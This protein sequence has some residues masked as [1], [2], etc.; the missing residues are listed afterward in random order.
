MLPVQQINDGE[1]TLKRSREYRIAKGVWNAGGILV[2][3]LIIWPNLFY[4]AVIQIAPEGTNHPYRAAR[5]LGEN[6]SIFFIKLGLK[7]SFP[8]TRDL[9]VSRAIASYLDEYGGNSEMWEIVISLLTTTEWEKGIF[10]SPRIF[11]DKYVYGRWEPIPGEKRSRR[12]LYFPVENVQWANEHIFKRPRNHNI[13]EELLIGGTEIRK[14]VSEEGFFSK[15][16]LE[17]RIAKEAWSVMRG[18]L[19]VLIFWPA[20]LYY[21]VIRIAPERTSHPCRAAGA[22]GRSGGIFFIKLGLRS[23]SPN[24]R[25]LMV[26]PAIA[27]YLD[28]RGGN[29]EIWEIIVSL[30]TATEWEK[31]MSVSSRV[32]LKDYVY[33]R[34]DFIPEEKRSRR[35]PYFPVENIQWANEHIFKRPRNHNIP[36]ELLRGERNG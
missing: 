31:R 5:A 25:S 15:N 36:E 12:V 28:R 30:L 29:P 17:F 26:N 10:A 32:F 11:L 33:G 18:L 19:L 27:S 22:L 16:R 7:S 20:P 34:V 14:G 13:P 4:Y 23:S 6:G 3:V 9:M 1:P 21:A 35:V 2:L 24:T 8:N